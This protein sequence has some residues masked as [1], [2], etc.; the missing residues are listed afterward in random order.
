MPAI[1]QL[2]VLAYQFEARRQLGDLGR[3]DHPDL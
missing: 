2:S 3:R 1:G